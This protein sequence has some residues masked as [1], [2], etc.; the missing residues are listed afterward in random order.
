M[1]I[2]DSIFQDCPDTGRS[3]GAYIMFYQGW[4]IDH[5]QYVSGS[6]AQHGTESEYNVACTAVMDLVHFSMLDNEFINKDPDVV[7][8]Q[9]PVIILDS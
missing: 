8:E 4:P 9:A 3:T 7:T 1:V 6:V 2:S 5:F